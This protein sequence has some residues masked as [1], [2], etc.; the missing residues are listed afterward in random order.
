MSP[1][2]RKS[3]TSKKPTL[4]KSNKPKITQIDSYK[5][6]LGDN[7]P[8]RPPRFFKDMTESEMKHFTR[9]LWKLPEGCDPMPKKAFQRWYEEMCRLNKLNEVDKIPPI[10]PCDEYISATHKT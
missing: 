2:K 1:R 7:A 3:R 4:E 8:K 5:L 6:T 10:Y 9:H